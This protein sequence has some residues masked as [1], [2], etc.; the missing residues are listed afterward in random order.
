MSDTLAM[1]AR[2]ARGQSCDQSNVGMASGPNSIPHPEDECQMIV[3]EQGAGSY[4]PNLVIW[5][6]MRHKLALSMKGG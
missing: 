3:A 6:G 2:C 1:L 5:N 4:G